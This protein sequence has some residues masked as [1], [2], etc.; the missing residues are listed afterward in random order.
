MK[1]ALPWSSRF[2]FEFNLIGIKLL[3]TNQ[4]LSLIESTKKSYQILLLTKTSRNFLK[5]KLMFGES[6]G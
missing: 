6:Y 3:S 4:I 2:L 1:L 5:L